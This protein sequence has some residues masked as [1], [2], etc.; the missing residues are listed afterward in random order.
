VSTPTSESSKLNLQ[1]CDWTDIYEDG[2]GD[3]AGVG[4]FPWEEF[5]AK[6]IRLL[7][8]ALR[9]K[10]IRN[11]K[12]ADMIERLVKT[13]RLKKTYDVM[14]AERKLEADND[15][16]AARKQ[17]QC[18]FRLMNILFSDEFAED[19]ADLGNIASRQLLDS[20]KA[21][22]QQHFWERVA[23]AFLEER[24]EFGVLRFTD[25]EIVNDNGHIDPAKIVKHDW[26]KLR[27]I[28]KLVN[29][30]YKTALTKFTQ[31]GTHDHNFFLFCNNKVETYYLRKYLD[32]RPN[33]TATVE[34]DLPHDCAISSVGNTVE[35]K[36][37]AKSVDSSNKK[38]RANEIADALMEYQ[39]GMHGSEM[40][41]KKLHYLNEDH[42]ERKRRNMMEDW[43]KLN[44]AIRGFYLDLQN[45]AF[46]DVYKKRLADDIEA[47]L[48]QKEEL[49]ILLGLRKQK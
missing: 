21:G 32:L 45:A 19:F 40:A 39:G 3:A 25:D 14:R 41:K 1:A 42:A 28:W 31:S 44:E 10:S 30:D 11:A 27:R 7:C 29:A 33:I 18:P 9:I 26:K 6:Q 37:V 48:V 12:K 2:N 46:D 24:P 49:G 47:L 15:D 20:G 17:L 23:S 8:T 13:Y 22:N 5:Q 38:K 4:G 36:A 34:A 43:T 35:E 16:K